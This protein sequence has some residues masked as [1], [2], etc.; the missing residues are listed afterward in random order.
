MKATREMVGK[1]V[2]WQERADKD[3]EWEA[4]QSAIVDRVANEDFA[5]NVGTKQFPRIEWLGEDGVYLRVVRV[6]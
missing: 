5:I 6:K 2:V 3:S 1:I 4:E